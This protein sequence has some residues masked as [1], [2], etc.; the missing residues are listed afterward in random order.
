MCQMIPQQ[1]V[2]LILDMHLD[3]QCYYSERNAI[4]LSE[5]APHQHR[6]H[7]GEKHIFFH[8][9]TSHVSLTTPY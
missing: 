7:Q 5:L 9:I 1:K 6:A 3:L 4:N 2:K 8:P